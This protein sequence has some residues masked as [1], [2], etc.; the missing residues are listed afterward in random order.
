MFYK[1]YDQPFYIP[2]KDKE[3]LKEMTRDEICRKLIELNEKSKQE[4]F[5]I[6]MRRFTQ[7]MAE[8]KEIRGQ[9]LDPIEGLRKSI[10]DF[11]DLIEK[12]KNEKKIEKTM[13]YEEDLFERIEDALKYE[14]THETGVITVKVDSGRIKEIVLDLS[15][16]DE[17]DY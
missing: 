2:D 3:R 13:S 10:M 11:N 17:D 16:P 12:T 6:P 14:L 4:G 15:W 8:I 7:L 1:I 9:K 5:M